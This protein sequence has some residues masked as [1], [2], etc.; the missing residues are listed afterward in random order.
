MGTDDFPKPPRPRD[1]ET[2]RKKNKTSRKTPAPHSLGYKIHYRLYRR[3]PSRAPP[4]LSFV[5]VF[6]ITNTIMSLSL[7]FFGIGLIL[8]RSVGCLS[9]QDTTHTRKKSHGSFL[10][11]NLNSCATRSPGP[12]FAAGFTSHKLAA[13]FRVKNFSTFTAKNPVKK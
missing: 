4:Q 6:H 5:F 8:L 12:M 13:E 9:P 11:K 10:V 1:K 7:P 3:A 2:R